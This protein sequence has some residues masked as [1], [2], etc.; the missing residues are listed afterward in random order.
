MHVEQE[1]EDQEV[2]PPCEGGDRAADGGKVPQE[3]EPQ[4][5]L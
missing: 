1:E 2:L 5:P 3:K 4:F